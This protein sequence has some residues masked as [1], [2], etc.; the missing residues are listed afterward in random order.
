MSTSSPHL[1]DAM[2]AMLNG[3][4]LEV[5]RSMKN[6]ARA[7]LNF[8][9]AQ[10]LHGPKYN[11]V[12]LSGSWERFNALA[13][14]LGAELARAQAVL[15]RD[16]AVRRAERELREAAEREQLRQAQELDVT[17]E[18]VDQVKLGPAPDDDVD[19]AD[20]PPQQ[21]QQPKPAAAKPVAPAPAAAAPPKPPAIQTNTTAA[22]APATATSTDDLFGPTPTTA[23][24][25][26]PDFDSMFDDLTAGNNDTANSATG[27]DQS[28]T[29]DNGDLDFALLPGLESYANSGDNGGAAQQQQ[30][31]DAAAGMDLGALDASNKQD[32]QKAAEDEEKKKK[33]AEEQAQ[34][35]QQQQQEEP[36]QT[37]PAEDEVQ[38]Q[39]FDP[40][41]FTG[42]STFDELFNYGDFDM[43][44]SAGGG[45]ETTFD[46]SFFGI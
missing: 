3:A 2:Q 6:P 10:G 28:T 45:T 22:A 14:E 40:N 31:A 21:Q 4:L 25:N 12:N 37:Q 33:Q 46:D 35:Q 32:E 34:Q 5:G 15:R 24:M 20:G 23:S 41:A 29:A 7:N 43:G 26:N 27:G 38:S 13:D 18:E 39:E 8:A 17:M 11:N 44:D 9:T 36:Q 30:P 1:L 19:M 42:E 16:L